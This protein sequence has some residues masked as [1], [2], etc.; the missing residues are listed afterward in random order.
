MAAPFL[1]DLK[2]LREFSISA[3]ITKMQGEK[4]NNYKGPC[5]LRYYC[6]ML[7]EMTW[8]LIF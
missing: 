5:I 3:K 6:I 8:V 1:L 2:D 4:I 7:E